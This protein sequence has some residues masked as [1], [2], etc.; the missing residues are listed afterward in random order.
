MIIQ[1]NLVPPQTA[2]CMS[3]FIRQYARAASH[4]FFFFSQAFIQVK[5]HDNS[6]RNSFHTG[7]RVVV[8]DCDTR[9]VALSGIVQQ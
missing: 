9:N 1:V 7:T 4:D 3:L 5:N 8:F 2:G 6:F